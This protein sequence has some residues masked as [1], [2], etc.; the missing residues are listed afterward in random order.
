MT[1]RRHTPVV[2]PNGTTITAPTTLYVLDLLRWHP[3]GQCR[4]DFAGRD[5]F[6]VSARIAELR[7]AGF[8]F[9]VTPCRRHDHRTGVVNYRLGADGK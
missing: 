5:V 1:T 8:T 7:A 9:T 4:R 3:D 6:E 2:G